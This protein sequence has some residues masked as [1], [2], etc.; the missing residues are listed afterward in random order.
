M[1]KTGKNGENI[2]GNPPNP[3]APQ[4]PAPRCCPVGK[5]R[6]KTPTNSRAKQ[7]RGARVRAHPAAAATAAAAAAAAVAGVEQQHLQQPQHSAA[8]RLLAPRRDPP[9]STPLRWLPG[10]AFGSNSGGE[11]GRRGGSA[12]P[13]SLLRL[14]PLRAPR[15]AL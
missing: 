10:S 4:P 3:A 15:P 2:K 7:G 5:P 1:V 6:P 8:Q 9:Y 13:A 12:S 14:A 11:S